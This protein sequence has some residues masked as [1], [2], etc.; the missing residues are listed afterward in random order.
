MRTLFLLALSI[1]VPAAG[2][3]RN[4]VDRAVAL[5]DDE[6]YE[7]AALAALEVAQEAKA[8][9]VQSDAQLMVGK[10]LYRMGLYHAALSQFAR[11]AAQG[12]EGRLFNKALEW[13]VFI[14]HKTANTS[15][16]MDEVARYPSAQFP[17]RFRSEIY[18]LL[19]RHHA[20]KGRLHDIA[21]RR[22]EGDK[23]FATSTSFAQQVGP[24]DDFYAEAKYLIALAEFREG[25]FQAA[26]DSL[27]EV[28][29]HTRANPEKSKARASRDRRV[30]DLAFMQLGRI[31]YGKKQFR[32][33]DAYFRKVSRG[34]E[35]WI[36]SLFEDAWATYRMNQDEKA[37]GNLVTLSA[38]PF[39][40]AYYPEALIL[41]A[42]IAYQNC[43]FDDA[44]TRVTEFEKTYVPVHK[45]LLALSES[46]S[47]PAAFYQ[48][49]ADAQADGGAKGTG[50][51][52]QRI[53]G[54]ALSDKE[55]QRLN[56]S[57]R[58]LDAELDGL[59]RTG[60]SFRYSSLTASLLTDLK[61]QRQALVEKAGE[62]A[63]SKLATE[64]T[65]LAALIQNAL[66]IRFETRAGEV[67]KLEAKLRPGGAADEVITE[68]D[69]AMEVG[70]GQEYWPQR[71]EFWRDELGTYLYTLS[72]GCA[73][74]RATGA[75]PGD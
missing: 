31:H 58:E 19:A 25:R 72:A 53:L 13:L 32:H 64:G 24:G 42:V 4:G 6:D 26:V 60:D 16:M 29:R 43:R 61:S 36:E 34:G 38:P 44:E 3:D 40:N 28:V 48:L 2:A 56:E 75:M 11:L 39:R 41:Q 15:V 5:F 69:L 37:L 70:D 68:Y 10:S 54:V 51:I 27:K 22:A 52:M 50:A 14:A 30:R 33:A 73:E 18:F 17:D 65:E 7:G 9:D 23:G 63:R 67:R 62:L 35:Q 1:A 74:Q 66:R 49:L 55:F 57:I 45:R 59:G 46:G 21:G 71:E 12:P 20:S 47:D 8:L